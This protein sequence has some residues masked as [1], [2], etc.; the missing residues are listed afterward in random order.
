MISGRMFREKARFFAQPV[1]A[2][3][4]R[5]ALGYGLGMKKVLVQFVR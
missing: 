5:I 4:S 1:C 2:V 3:I